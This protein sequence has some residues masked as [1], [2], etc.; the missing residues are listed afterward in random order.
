LDDIFDETA[1]PDLL[2]GLSVADDAAVWK[3][4]DD[5]ALVFTADFFTPIV[6]DPYDYGAIAAAN[7]LSDIYA[8]G[9]EP[10]LALNLA[11]LPATMPEEIIA[12]ILRGSAEKVKEAGAIIAG[13]H[14]IDDDEPK[15][16]MAVLGTVHPER[17]GTK[18]KACPGDLLILTKPLGTG[19]IT[20]AFKA[21]EADLAHVATATDWMKRL[22]RD[23]AIALRGAPLHAVTDITGFGLLGHAWEVAEKSGVRLRIRFDDLPFHPGAFEYA[24]NLL[25]PAMANR[26][27]RDYGGSVLFTKELEYEIRLLTFCPETSGGLFISLPPHEAEGFLSR[28]EALGHQA[29]IVGE[30]LEGAQQ[31]EVI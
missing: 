9:G 30:V 21:D 22:N 27:M 17:I 2:V 12:D 3:L 29:W 11:A 31:I 16:G 20:T 15:F 4:S 5:R 18:A 26:N 19:I 25:F 7:A 1:Y 8:M 24:A 28:Y 23:A 14:T 10:F 6:D 13:G